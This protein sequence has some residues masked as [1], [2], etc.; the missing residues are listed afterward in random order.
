MV[1][2]IRGVGVRGSSGYVQKI[3]IN[4]GSNFTLASDAGFLALDK[5]KPIE[6]TL[7]GTFYATSTST[8]AFD[9]GDLSTWRDVHVFVASGC[10]VWGK[11][12][13][14][15]SSA[16]SSGPGAAGGTAFNVNGANSATRLAVTIQSG[17]EVGGGGGGGG[18]G[19]RLTVSSYRQVTT[20]HQ[21]DECNFNV[22]V[23]RGSG[24]GGGGRSSSQSTTG[25]GSG[26]TSTTGHNCAAG[27]NGGGGGT[28]TVTGAGGGGANGLG[29]YR[30]FINS[31]SCGNCT[32]ANGL[33]GA[34]GGTWATAGSGSSSAGGAG[35]QSIT[36][37]ASCTYTNLGTVY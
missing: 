21:G 4:G 32:N 22:T 36:N 29:R 26:S 8:P 3:T 15:A 23:Q 37:T 11:G 35:G 7:T 17:A 14:G 2:G 30:P 19:N 28:G 20:Q 1:A 5:N 25:G 10:D 24:G 33:S 34:G 16:A 18:A 6:V 9:C 27:I 12:G 13:A 31:S